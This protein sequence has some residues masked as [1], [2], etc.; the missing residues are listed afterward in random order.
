LASVLN[1]CGRSGKGGAAIG[2][3]LRDKGSTSEAIGT[4]EESRKKILSAV[5]ELDAKGLNKMKNIQFFDNNT[6][7]FT[8]MLCEIAIRY[9][10]S[11]DMP[12]VG[13]SRSNGTTKVS[14]RCTHELLRRGVDLSVAMR[15]AGTSMGGGGGGH[16][17]ASGAW[18]PAGRENEFLDTLDKIIEKQISAK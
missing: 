17:I 3:G 14:S 4:D 6:S 2:Y 13:Y 18:F 9:I 8:G 1:S 11:A 15:D 16:K 12:V 5:M 7:G 10:G